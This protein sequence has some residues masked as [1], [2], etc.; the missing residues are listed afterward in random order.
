M[1]TVLH[2]VIFKIVVQFIRFRHEKMIEQ[3]NSENTN[4]EIMQ[5]KNSENMFFLMN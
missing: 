3:S 1:V 4:S 2:V 5:Y